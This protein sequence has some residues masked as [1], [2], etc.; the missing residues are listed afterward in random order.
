VSDHRRPSGGGGLVGRHSAEPE[1]ESASGHFPINATFNPAVTTV[2]YTIPLDGFAPGET[3]Y[4]G[5]Q[6]EV[7]A[8]GGQGGSQTAWGFGPRFGGDNWATY[9]NYQV[10]VCIIE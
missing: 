2:T 5:A 1:P 8:P 3:L 9:I 7:Q 6:A 10:Q 4:I